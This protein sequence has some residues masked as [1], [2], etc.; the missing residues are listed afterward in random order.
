MDGALITAFVALFGAAATLTLSRLRR[1]R[2]TAS[3][4]L[5]TVLGTAAVS[6]TATV[7]AYIAFTSWDCPPDFLCDYPGMFAAGFAFGAIW[8]IC[9]GVVY[10]AV[11]FVVVRSQARSRDAKRALTPNTSFERTRE[12]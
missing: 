5:L 1:V 9:Y 3:K 10:V 11:A 4:F 12:G 6:G 2:L 7:L 8:L